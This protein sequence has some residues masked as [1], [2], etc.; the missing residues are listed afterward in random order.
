MKIYRIVFA[1]LLVL[2]ASCVNL[3]FDGA[4]YSQFINIKYIADNR[5]NICQDYDQL[6]KAK[7]ELKTIIDKEL[8]YSKYRIEKVATY[9]AVK[10]LHNIISEF[11]SKQNMSK[12]YCLLKLE[13]ISTG[14]LLI[15]E[16]LGKMN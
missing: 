14:S 2:L 10:N 4:E 11:D 8:I 9:E 12:P 1:I 16:E 7:L 13:N 5:A 6:N 3:N 15:I